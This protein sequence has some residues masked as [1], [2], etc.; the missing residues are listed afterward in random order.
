[1]FSATERPARVW[2]NDRAIAAKR[3]GRFDAPLGEAARLDR[4]VLV[5]RSSVG[6]IEERNRLLRLGLPGPFPE[7]E[8][9]R[10]LTLQ[11]TSIGLE[12][13]G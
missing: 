6:G 9:L 3:I 12:H 13:C 5:E 2:A 8:D 1:M 10:E 11:L 4:F 7:T